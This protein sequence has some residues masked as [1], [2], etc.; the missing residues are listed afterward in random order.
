MLDL[1][2]Q[3]GRDP[4]DD[5]RVIDGELAAYSAELAAR[6]QIIVANK[7]DLPDALPNRERVERHC[8]TNGLPLFV[9]SAATGIGLTELVRA[10]DARLRTLAPAEPGATAATSAEPRRAR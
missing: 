2:P 3:T 5:L 8:A 9:I 6:P 4:L 10:I 7:A 1:D